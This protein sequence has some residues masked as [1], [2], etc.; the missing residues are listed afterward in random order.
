MAT[1]TIDRQF[2]TKKEEVATVHR[3]CIRPRVNERNRRGANVFDTLATPQQR[4]FRYY[5][6]YL[7][8]WVYNEYVYITSK[9]IYIV[10]VMYCCLVWRPTDLTARAPYTGR[11]K[12]ANAHEIVR[13]RRMRAFNCRKTNLNA[14]I[15]YFFFSDVAVFSVGLKSK[16]PR[17]A[18]NER[19]QHC[20]RPVRCAT[21]CTCCWCA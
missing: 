10:I 12:K 19:M 9:N 3:A 21:N 17:I 4:P 20:R 11:K 13:E 5:T 14:W 1:L 7:H 8:G 6:Y 15:F 2:R 16:T 18:F